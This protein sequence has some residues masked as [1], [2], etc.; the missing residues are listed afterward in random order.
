MV[1]TAGKHATDF[2]CAEAHGDIQGVLPLGHDRSRLLGN[3]PISTPFCV[4]GDIL[5]SSNEA[6]GALQDAACELAAYSA[7]RDRWFR[8]L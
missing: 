3:A 5:S 8:G 2:L 1:D 4:Y 6:H 7:D